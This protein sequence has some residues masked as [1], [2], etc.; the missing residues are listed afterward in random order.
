MNVNEEGASNILKELFGHICDHN[1]E[2]YMY[3]FDRPSSN[4]SDV[5][6]AIENIRLGQVV[7]T[8]VVQALADSISHISSKNSILKQIEVNF[9]QDDSEL[10]KGTCTLCRFRAFSFRTKTKDFIL[11]VKFNVN[12]TELKKN[13][14]DFRLQ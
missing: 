9:H 2:Q 13:V 12:G 11:N 8:E 6:E 4:A 7:N 14:L 10:A 3:N 1:D 5:K